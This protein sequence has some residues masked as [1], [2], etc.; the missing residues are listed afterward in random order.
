MHD[1]L[2]F[3][4]EDDS[5]LEGLL[6]PFTGHLAGNRDS[7]QTRFSARTEYALNWFPAGRPLLYQHGLDQ[8]T[9]IVPVGRINALE[10]RDAGVWMQAQL[11]KG[12]QYFESIR[13]LV[14][15][16]KL[17][18]SSGSV[19]HLVQIDARS[20]D[21]TCWPIVEGSLTPTPANLHATIAAR[22]IFADCEAVGAAPPDDLPSDA[23]ITY[24]ATRAVWTQKYIDS[25]PDS[26]FAY[27]EDG[28]DKDKSKRHLPY[29]DKAGNVDAAH[30]KAALSR[31]D[32]T[33]IPAAA[34]AAAKRKLMAAAKTLGIDSDDAARSAGALWAGRDAGM[35][36]GDDAPTAD[37][38]LPATSLTERSFEDIRADI[39]T[40]LNPP[41]PFGYG[42]VWTDVVAT[43][44]DHVIVCRYENGDG[45]YYRIPYTLGASLEPV[46]GTPEP[47]EQVY[48]SARTAASTG[49]ITLEATALI[50]RTAALT[51]RTQ[52]LGERRY[53]EGRMLSTAN[54]KVLDDH[55]DH[56]EAAAKTIRDLTKRAKGME[57]ETARAA[58]WSDPDARKW[59]I[60]ALDV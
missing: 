13:E 58:F 51:E 43:F 4:A 53:R 8:E 7:Y 11:D 59:L 40:I 3:A 28:A 27:V 6:V 26:A 36:D 57:A 14:K 60:A 20:G 9:G 38:D 23:T 15:K 41:N 30:V 19:E 5:V 31:L 10:V 22:S 49:P 35:D 54:L 37:G 56:L 29:K 21:V 25:L 42:N 46:L 34:K 52:D 50:R 24:D 32:Q 39:V 33:D 2:R 44:A 16:G 1:A 48:V 55:A 45:D 17:F 12:H 47:V 18:L